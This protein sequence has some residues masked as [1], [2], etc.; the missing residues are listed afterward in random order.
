MPTSIAPPSASSALRER[1]RRQAEADCWNPRA[2]LA[3][4]TEFDAHRERFIAEIKEWLHGGNR[5]GVH[6]LGEMAWEVV[7]AINHEH[8]KQMLCLDFNE[9]RQRVFLADGLMQ[10]LG[11][12]KDDVEDGS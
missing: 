7:H 3:R 9:K 1:Y 11:L 12:L 6:S 10:Y 8:G 4:F 2:A 5:R